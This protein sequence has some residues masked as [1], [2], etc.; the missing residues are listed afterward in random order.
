MK[1][2]EKRPALLRVFGAGVAGVGILMTLN[3]MISGPHAFGGGH[4]S[5]LIMTTL[6]VI[7]TLCGLCVMLCGRPVKK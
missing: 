6:G 5:V 3:V 2:H 7:V 1:M 4:I